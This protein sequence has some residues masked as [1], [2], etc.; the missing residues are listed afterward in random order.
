MQINFPYTRLNIPNT[1]KK[2]LNV[3]FLTAK[4]LASISQLEFT[5]GEETLKVSDEGSD[6]SRKLT[7]HNDLHFWPNT[8]W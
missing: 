4:V 6:G 3:F 1:L 5:L 8:V 2:E 7:R